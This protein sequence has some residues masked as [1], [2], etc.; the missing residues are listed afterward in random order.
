MSRTARDNRPN[1]KPVTKV[2]LNE[3]Y[4]K[5]RLALVVLLVLVAA[6]AF[7]YGVYSLLQ[8]EPGWVEIEAN[9]G[10]GVTCADEFVF[11]YELGAGE[12][13]AT[14]EKKALT[15]LYT[16]AAEQA[17]QIFNSD[18]LFEGVHNVYTLNRHPNEVLDVD[19][20]LYDA[21]SLLQSYENRNL[22][23]APVYAR[24]ENLFSCT[25]DVQAEEY[26]PYR[27][28]D[29]AAEYQE[30]AAYAADPSQVDVQLLGG[31]K[32]RLFVSEEYLAYAEENGI[33]EFIDFFWMKNAFL[34][35]YI[36]DRLI[37]NGY[38]HG[39]LSSYDGF[40][41]NLDDRDVT[42][43]LNLYDRVGQAVYEAAVLEYSGARSFV[44]LRDH[45]M[46][47]LDSRH[48]YEYAN[49]ET[50]SSYVDIQDARCRSAVPDLTAYSAEMGCAR[51]LLEVSPLYIVDDLDGE[52]LNALCQRGVFSVYCKDRTVCYNDTALNLS[53]FYDRDGVR[54]T[55]RYQPEPLPQSS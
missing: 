43:S 15:L 4:T 8:Q 3:K 1:L 14:A 28:S 54:Y 40:S 49:G 6:A 17:C 39:T 52:A 11:L 53:Q 10:S 35:D 27:S 55:S 45:K 22:Y 36:A 31:G 7:G 38:T 13:S 48:Y 50:R 30:L 29:A 12:L 42:Y 18:T 16:Q 26:D 23:L 33:T 21:F 32:V 37:E 19:E 34:L 51:L 41:R 44:S 2:R 5:V 9:S 24:Y 47:Q 46:T 25:D 20:A